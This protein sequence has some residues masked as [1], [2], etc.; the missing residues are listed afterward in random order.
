MLEEKIST[1]QAET[2]LLDVLEGV[3]SVT[4]TS[5]ASSTGGEHQQVWTP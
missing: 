3:C 5:C 2:K 1:E 4:A